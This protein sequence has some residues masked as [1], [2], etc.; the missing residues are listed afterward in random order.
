M[1]ARTQE[2]KRKRENATLPLFSVGGNTPHPTNE[3]FVAYPIATIGNPEHNIAGVDGTDVSRAMS[4]QVLRT[5]TTETLLQRGR[6]AFH[7]VLK[8]EAPIVTPLWGRAQWTRS[9]RV[10]RRP[11]SLRVLDIEEQETVHNIGT[12]G[13]QR[14][15]CSMHLRDILLLP[16]V[17][18]L[19]ERG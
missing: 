13:S 8:G 5:P 2:R 16:R 6:V 14:E 7:G 3:L 19:D 15:C 10:V 11:V 9:I 17:P 1:R 12:H 4:V 18:C